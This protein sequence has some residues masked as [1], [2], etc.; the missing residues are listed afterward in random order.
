MEVYKGILW[1][2]PARWELTQGYFNGEI[3]QG[4]GIFR[5]PIERIWCS[6]FYVKNSVWYV[7]KSTKSK[8]LSF[9]KYELGSMFYMPGEKCRRFYFPSLEKEFMRGFP[10]KFSLTWQ[11]LQAK[12]FKSRY[13]K[14]G[15][16]AFSFLDNKANVVHS[17]C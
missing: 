9:N 1:G 2:E 3:L 16:R 15:S 4:Q 11:I 7:C 6:G 5:K 13:L 8:T 14:N 12:V 17:S 10:N